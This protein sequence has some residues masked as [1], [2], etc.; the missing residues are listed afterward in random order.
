MSSSWVDLFCAKILK[1]FS[2]IITIVEDELVHGYSLDKKDGKI[3]N[4][5]LQ[6]QWN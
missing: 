2:S 1:T 3:G 4:I 5:Y 6:F